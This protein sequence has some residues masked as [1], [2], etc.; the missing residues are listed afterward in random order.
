MFSSR[1]KSR[2]CFVVMIALIGLPITAFADESVQIG[3]LG[4]EQTAPGSVIY[5]EGVDFTLVGDSYPG[6]VETGVTAV[7]LDLG[8]G[9]ASTSGCEAEDFAAFPSG[10]I[11]L[12]Q[13]GSCF[14]VTKAENAANAGAS[15]VIIFNQG[16]TESRTGLINIWL[17]DS[18]SGA[19]PVF[20]ATYDRGEEWAGIEGL[21]MNLDAT[22][23]FRGPGE[24]AYLQYCV[25]NP[26]KCAL[27]VRHVTEGWER[28][29]NPDR[30]QVTASTYKILMLIAYAEAVV[31]GEIDPNEVID[32]DDWAKYSVRQD[33]GAMQSMFD[34][35]GSPTTVTIDEMVRGMLQDSDN[36]TPDWLRDRLG[37]N[38]LKKVVRRFIDGYHDVPT[39]INSVFVTMDVNPLEVGMVTRILD[40]YSGFDAF[41]FRKEVDD[42]FWGEMQDPNFPKTVMD[43]RCNSVPWE[44]PPS[45]CVPLWETTTQQ[46]LDFFKNFFTQS[47][48]RTYMNLMDG[49]L[50]GD[51]V[52]RNVAEVVARHLEFRLEDPDFSDRFS[53]HG[54]KAGGFTPQDICNWASFL[55]D[56]DTG[57]Q[58]VVSAF[59]Q[60]SPFP[61]GVALDPW[62]FAEQFALNLDFAD[63]VRDTIPVAEELPEL[64][65]RVTERDWLSDSGIAVLRGLVELQNIS[66]AKPDVS[67]TIRLLISDDR[68]PDPG[69][70]VVSTWVVDRLKRGKN[71]LPFHWLGS[72]PDG[73]YLLLEVDAYDDVEEGNEANNLVIDRL[74]K[75]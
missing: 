46:Y 13:R 3:P 6:V 18:F 61:C 14:F 36:A 31:T 47:S 53:R 70:D 17:G 45:G 1:S 73:R 44:S 2:P 19:I 66:P 34:R 59:V 39:S 62:T 69:D 52:N 25:S 28:H 57:D 29:L 60:N 9:N 48:S 10:H 15:A 72:D 8:L 4:L 50:R 22:N 43:L 27:S 35:L 20:F 21:V 32:R 37:D 40:D 55:E 26:D 64:L 41:G 12:V 16:D 42:I 5:V 74:R 7:D 68:T 30:L 33:G 23:V 67:F 75:P 65:A 71:Q 49:L 54:A 24:E 11:A 56:A 58:V 38:A 63:L 51:L